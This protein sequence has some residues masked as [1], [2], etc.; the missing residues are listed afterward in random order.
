[1]HIL[2]GGYLPLDFENVGSSIGVTELLKNASFYEENVKNQIETYR[3]FK[4]YLAKVFI[5][6]VS[7]IREKLIN[8]SFSFDCP[9]MST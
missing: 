9:L 3:I 4:I 1:M 7:I 8:Q 2:K 5:S 6:R